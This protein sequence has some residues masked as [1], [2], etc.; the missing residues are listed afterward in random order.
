MANNDNGA[1]I[2]VAFIAGAAVGAAVALLFAPATGEETREYL[3]QR[4]REGRDRAVDAA[5]QG[6]E[7]L[8]K[9]RDNITNAF[10]RA[11]QQYQG[12]SGEGQD[13]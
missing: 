7:L 2:L 1:G 8:N 5:R 10:D 9:Q 13:A 12:A 3:G 11:R 4:A 6:R